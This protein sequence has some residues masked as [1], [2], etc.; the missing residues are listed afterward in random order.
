MKF[1]KLI[2]DGHLKPRKVWEQLCRVFFFRAYSKNRSFVSVQS[3]GKVFALE[4]ETL[5][6][7]SAGRTT[8]LDSRI[9][10]KGECKNYLFIFL[11]PFFSN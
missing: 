2:S 1:T 10:V 7:N 3:P 4:A 6:S 11:S 5:T 9:V 8:T